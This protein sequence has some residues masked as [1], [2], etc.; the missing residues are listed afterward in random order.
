[1][2]GVLLWLRHHHVPQCVVVAVIGTLVCGFLTSS[3]AFIT[4]VAPL[5]CATLATIPMLFVV[6]GEDD[7]D[8]TSSRSLAARRGVLVA[9]GAAVIICLAVICYPDGGEFGMETMLRDSLALA[10][11]GAAST[12]LLPVTAIWVVP[13]LVALSLIHI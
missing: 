4:D 13:L 6:I 10:G 11:L 3:D 2:R 1:M 8:R 5:W 9:V 7:M 12:V